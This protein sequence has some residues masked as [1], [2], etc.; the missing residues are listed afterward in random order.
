MSPKTQKRAAAGKPRARKRRPFIIRRSDVHGR[1][2]FATEWI[3]NGTRLIEYTGERIS[4]DAAD[5]RY[6]DDD[7]SQPYHTFLFSLDDGTVVD[8]A[9]GGNVSRY[10]N[11]SCDPNCEA[12]IEDDRIFIDAIR[13]IAP[14]EELY[15]D[16]SFVLEERHTPAVKR[17]YPCYCGSE[18]CRGTILAPK[19]KKRS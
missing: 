9:Y 10:I 16:Y 12:V 11:H 14:G 2:A 5:R 18:N 1:G 4:E 3:R 15:Y 17:R 13:E 8:A 7:E 19:R 6:D